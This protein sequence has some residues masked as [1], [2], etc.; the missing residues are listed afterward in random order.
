MTDRAPEAQARTVMDGAAVAE[1][2]QQLAARI[3]ETENRGGLCLVGVRRGGVPLAAR[4]GALLEKQ[5]GTAVPRGT[6]DIGLYR[7]D[8]ARVHPVVGPTEISFSVQD[9]P[10][11]LVDDVLFTGRTIRAALDELMDFGRPRRVYLAVL[12]DRGGRELPIAPDFIGR[13]IDCPPSSRVE[14][15][16]S[17]L[18]G[19]D[20]VMVVA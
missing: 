12:V 6:L 8:V 14:V 10:V 3:L 18:D 13:R 20:A 11:V 17:E 2:I 4:L 15:R 16:F 7:D 5:L 19:Q 9:R 1:A